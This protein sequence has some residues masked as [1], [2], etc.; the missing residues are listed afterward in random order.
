[1]N[2]HLLF[3]F[4][5]LIS[6]AQCEGNLIESIK[7]EIQK[8]TATFPSSYLSVIQYFQSNTDGMFGYVPLID[9]T[10]LKTSYNLPDQVFKNFRAI[11]FS[12][13]VVVQSFNILLE[14]N[15]AHYN[16]YI[17]AGVRVD[18]TMFE[19]AYIRSN[20]NA[21]LKPQYNYYTVRDCKRFLFFK[22]CKT[23]QKQIQRGY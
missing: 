3:L 20:V 10:S 5:L 21:I 18:S 15:L 7:Q 1:M 6:Y 22:K 2:N 4:L 12:Q 19:F 14:N 17:G 13:S 11:A 23:I 9:I 16:Q 8:V